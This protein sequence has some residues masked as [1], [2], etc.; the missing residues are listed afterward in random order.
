MICVTPVEMAVN[1]NIVTIDTCLSVDSVYW[2]GSVS[3]S[4]NIALML[5]SSCLTEPGVDTA[6]YLIIKG[7][8]GYGNVTG[9]A[10]A[11]VGWPDRVN[12]C[13]S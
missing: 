2:Y 3:T 8:I 6:A 4:D 10:T 7:T 5:H 13:P 1:L 12:G 11:D 9:G